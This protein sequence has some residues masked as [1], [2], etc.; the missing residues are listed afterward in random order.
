MHILNQYEFLN[1]VYNIIVTTVSLIWN[2]L[3]LEEALPLTLPTQ[4][5]KLTYMIIGLWCPVCLAHAVQ[6]IDICDNWA[7]DRY[8]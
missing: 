6:Q 2:I 5:S 7:S 3:S 4:C 8:I 1:A